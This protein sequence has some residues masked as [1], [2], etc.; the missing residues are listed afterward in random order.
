MNSQNL[1]RYR[2]HCP[3]RQTS[4]RKKSV[5]NGLFIR[6]LQ[7]CQSEKCVHFGKSV[8]AQLSHRDFRLKSVDKASIYK[9]FAQTFHAWGVVYREWKVCGLYG[10]GVF[11]MKKCINKCGCGSSCELVNAFA[12]LTREGKVLLSGD[13]RVTIEE[14]RCLR[15][16]NRRMVQ[17]KEDGESNAKG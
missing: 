7:T 4:K 11:V 6:F 5:K 13:A 3:Y 15:E 1:N 2:K 8:D 12:I 17:R 9:G 14:D 10:K 16:I